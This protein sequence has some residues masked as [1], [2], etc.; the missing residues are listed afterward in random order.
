[1]ILVITVMMSICAL[2][3]SQDE[4]EKL[5]RTVTYSVNRDAQEFTVKGELTSNPGYLTHTVRSGSIN[6]PREP[7]IKIII[8][9]A[10]EDKLKP[11]NAEREMQKAVETNMAE[12]ERLASGADVKI[13]AK[14]KATLANGEMVTVNPFKKVPNT[15]RNNYVFASYMLDENTAVTVTSSLDKQ[16]FEALLK[17]L[18]IGEL[19]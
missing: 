7:A 11:M 4:S 5:S 2:A 10:L 13:S 9:S 6:S 8:K 3:V 1:M 16:E 14:Y 19:T 12:I 15:Y 17:T 18:K